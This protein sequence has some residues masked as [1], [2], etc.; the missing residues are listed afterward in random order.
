MAAM[1]A[2]QGIEALFHIVQCP[3][4]IESGFF[5][6]RQEP[7]TFFIYMPLEGSLFMEALTKPAM[8]PVRAI[9]YLPCLY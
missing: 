5:S 9:I 7:I 1:G 4:D 8:L 3:C 2:Y 6:G